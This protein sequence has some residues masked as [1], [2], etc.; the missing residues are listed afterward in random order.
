MLGPLDGDHVRQ[1]H[2]TG[3]GRRVVRGVWLAEEPGGRDDEHEAAVALS[4]H[5]PERRLA[6]IEAAVEVHLQHPAPVGRRQL[7]EGRGVEDAG[8]ADD[9]V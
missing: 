5:D 4:L 7:V 3:L 8:V 1:A 9:G 6:Q 2:E